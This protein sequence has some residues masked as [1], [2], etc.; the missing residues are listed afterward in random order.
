[1]TEKS[2]ASIQHRIIN[3][4][5]LPLVKRYLI[6][7]MIAVLMA[8]QFARMANVF[9]RTICHFVRVNVLIHS[10]LMNIVAKSIRAELIVAIL[11][12]MIQH[13]KNVWLVNVYV[14]IQNHQ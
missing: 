4:V 7:A 3:I 5:A 8:M 13:E 2:S 12:K 10:L 6:I 11:N 14:N 9:V 1:M